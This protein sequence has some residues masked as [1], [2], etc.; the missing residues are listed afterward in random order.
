MSEII[1]EEVEVKEQVTDETTEETIDENAKALRMAAFAKGL[2]EVTS[3]ESVEENKEEETVVPK[4]LNEWYNEKMNE[5]G[6][7]IR[8]SATLSKIF[9]LFS[10]P[11]IENDG[12][13]VSANDLL[14][15][16]Q[17][18]TVTRAGDIE[19]VTM[20][21]YV[22]DRL[23][24]IINQISNVGTLSHKVEIIR[25]NTQVPLEERFI[26]FFS[27]LKLITNNPVEF[28]TF[29]TGGKVIFTEKES[30]IVSMI[31]ELILDKVFIQKGLKPFVNPHKN[32]LKT[33]PINITIPLKQLFEEIV[34]TKEPH[35]LEVPDFINNTSEALKFKVSFDLKEVSDT[36]SY[37]DD[38]RVVEYELYVTLSTEDGNRVSKYPLDIKITG[39]SAEQI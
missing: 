32:D 6:T 19:I 4:T 26:K 18:S 21:A 24:I 35:T 2:D 3:E 39:T 9:A 28:V 30:Y 22:G 20:L 11:L 15:N 23:P 7:V 14:S 1:K 8:P 38:T 36:L 12:N 25:V 17:F 37:V 29:D 5:V 13:L 34:S 10:I 33:N 27:E 31:R 16:V